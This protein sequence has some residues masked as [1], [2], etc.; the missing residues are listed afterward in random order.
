MEAVDLSCPDDAKARVSKAPWSWS[1]LSLLNSPRWLFRSS[2]RILFLAQKVSTHLN[3]RFLSV[4]VKRTIEGISHDGVFGHVSDFL[5]AEAPK[6]EEHKSKSYKTLKAHK[7][8]A[9]AVCIQRPDLEV[10]RS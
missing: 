4:G 5:A 2:Q 3:L 10:S 7:T 1:G 6:V 8:D 9:L